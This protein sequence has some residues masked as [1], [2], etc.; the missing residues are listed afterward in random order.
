MLLTMFNLRQHSKLNNVLSLNSA[1]WG[2]QQGTRA[3]VPVGRVRCVYICVYV[4]LEPACRD[5]ITKSPKN[6]TQLN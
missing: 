2:T 4:N 5:L 1:F 6:H 3:G